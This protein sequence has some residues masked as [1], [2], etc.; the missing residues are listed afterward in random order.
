MPN[1]DLDAIGKLATSNHGGDASEVFICHARRY[2][3]AARQGRLVCSVVSVAPS[4]MSRQI[5]ICELDKQNFKGATFHLYTFSR[6]FEFLGYKGTPT[7]R[8][9]TFRVTSVFDMHY[10]I[11]H[12]LYDLGFLTTLMR[13]KLIQ[14]KPHVI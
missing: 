5:R 7:K 13:D 12:Q 9:D 14:R 10:N 11:I 4:G 2:I 8:P 6:L 3:K 1:L